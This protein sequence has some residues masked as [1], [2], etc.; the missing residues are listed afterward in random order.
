MQT[1]ITGMPPRSN[2][3]PEVHKKMILNRR[4]AKFK[5]GKFFLIDLFREFFF[6]NLQ[7][8]KKDKLEN[9]LRLRLVKTSELLTHLQS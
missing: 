9:H 2:K 3:H 5:S 6:H 4:L 1:D 8:K 7:N